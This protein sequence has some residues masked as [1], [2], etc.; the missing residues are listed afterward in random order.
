MKMATSEELAKRFETE[1]SIDLSP[2][3]DL[4]HQL[5]SIFQSLEDKY[6]T[7]D[8]INVVI[9]KEVNG[10]VYRAYADLKSV[11]VIHPDGAVETVILVQRAGPGSAAKFIWVEPYAKIWL[12]ENS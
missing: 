7:D 5:L 12:R 4:K 9:E 2:L 8:D 1:M 11:D 3:V 10:I 6:A